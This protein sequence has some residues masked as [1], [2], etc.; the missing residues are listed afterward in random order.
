MKIVFCLILSIAVYVALG[1]LVPFTGKVALF[2]TILGSLGSFTYKGVLAF[3][4]F[5]SLTKAT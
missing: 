2:I 3:A 4:T 5:A 1:A